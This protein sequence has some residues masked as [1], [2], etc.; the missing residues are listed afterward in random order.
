MRVASRAP[1]RIE[2][3]GGGT[4]IPTYSNRHTGVVLSSTINKYVYSTLKPT[5]NTDLKVIKTDQSKSALFKDVHDLSYNGDSDL[6]KAVIKRLKINYGCEIYLRGDVPPD[7][8]LGSGATATVSLIGMFNQLRHKNKLSH[9]SIAQTAFETMKYE[10]DVQGGKQS[11]YSSVFGG[12]NFTEFLEG[13]HVRVNQIRPSKQTRLDLEKGMLL[14]YAGRREKI[15]SQTI[16][17]DQESLYKESKKIILLDKLKNYA[18]EM[19]DRLLASDIEGFAKLINQAYETKKILN[20]SISN[21][22]IDA[23]CNLA[24]KNGAMFN[25][26]QGA[27]GGG[28]L[29]IYCD[30]NKEHVVQKSLLEKGITSI[31]FSFTKTGLETWQGNQ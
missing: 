18:Y 8:G 13:G 22:K 9:Y 15:K 28:H 3:G 19:K 29:I 26:I 6:I 1:V 7:S 23:I 12:F 31:P 17:K 4:D 10:L 25:R 21:K 27:G 14:V 16:L 30:L 5:H 11:F 2:F 20:P 24:R